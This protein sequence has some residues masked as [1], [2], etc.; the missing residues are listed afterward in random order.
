MQLVVSDQLPQLSANLHALQT[1]LGGDLTPLMDAIGLLLENS[2]RERFETKRDPEGI[3][4]AQLKPKTI[5]RKRN[6]N[7]SIRGGILVDRADLRKSITYFANTQS[8]TV[9]SDRQYSQYHQ[10]GTEHMPARRFLGL[11]TE[12]VKEIDEFVRIFLEEEL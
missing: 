1:R 5:E 3:S 4:W 9:G 7:G 12:D 11:T 2:T 8:V 6:Q 10:T